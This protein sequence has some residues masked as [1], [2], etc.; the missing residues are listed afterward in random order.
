[1]QDPQV[2]HTPEPWQVWKF[3]D[4]EADLAVGPVAGGL[5]VC[6]VVTSEATGIRTPASVARGLANAALIAAAPR[7]LR[8]L[9]HVGFTLNMGDCD[10]A[11]FADSACDCMDHLW[12]KAEEIR[13]ILKALKPD[14]SDELRGH[15]GEEEPP[16]PEPVARDGVNCGCKSFD[17]CP[18][19][20]EAP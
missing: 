12:L 4:C 16:P 2:E 15:S 13:E 1:M 7:M 20:S 6:E 5:A 18:G 19:R 11:D 8:L 10:H 9:R 17:D 3:T 14:P